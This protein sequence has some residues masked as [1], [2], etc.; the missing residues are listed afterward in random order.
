MV[1][2]LTP[3]VLM[4]VGIPEYMYMCM[5]TIYFPVFR[6][7]RWPGLALQ[8]PKIWRCHRKPFESLDQ[9]DS[10][11]Q[12]SDSTEMWVH[13]RMY[14]ENQGGNA[15]PRDESYHFFFK[16]G[17][18]VVGSWRGGRGLDESRELLFWRYF[19]HFFFRQT[20]GYPMAMLREYMKKPPGTLHDQTFWLEIGLDFFWFGGWNN[21]PN[22]QVTW[23]S[24]T[25]TALDV[26]GWPHFAE[27]R[28]AP[29]LASI[30]W[31]GSRNLRISPLIPVV[32]WLGGKGNWV[33]KVGNPWDAP[34][35]IQD[36]WNSRF[37]VYHTSWVNMYIYI[38]ICYTFTNS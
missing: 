36:F 30:G 17:F 31:K 15:K 16:G 38:I 2:I 3:I 35:V 23:H 27:L 29:L 33:G 8:L 10:Q 20:W 5:H 28:I 22:N 6:T 14:P 24:Q 11:T 4:V 1:V 7:L 19:C 18:D 13:V 37:L 21:S 12:W 26:D 25:S 32:W 9:W 34:G